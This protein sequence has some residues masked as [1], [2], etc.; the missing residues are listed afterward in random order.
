[1]CVCQRVQELD[2][3]QTAETVGQ[4]RTTQPTRVSHSN[5]R[6][7]DEDRAASRAARATEHEG[8]AHRTA[9]A[10]LGWDVEDV[11][12]V[13]REYKVRAMDDPVD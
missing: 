8:R 5:S 11:D 3:R 7:P 9:A 4:R 10:A 6:S 1:M 12:E 2:C 13:H